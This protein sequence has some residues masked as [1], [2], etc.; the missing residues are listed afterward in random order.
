M[1]VKRTCDGCGKDALG[2]IHLDV[3]ATNVAAEGRTTGARVSRDSCETC[4]PKLFGEMF[5]EVTTQ[6]ETDL[7]RHR[8]MIAAREREANARAE[9]K[10]LVTSLAGEQPTGKA[11]EK[12][13]SLNR[14]IAAAEGEYDKAAKEGEP[15]L[16]V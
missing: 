5:D 14:E 15:V 16:E 7:P 8:V 4:R 3:Q 11:A 6:L 12:V 2:E 1:A 9:L 10:T 13:K